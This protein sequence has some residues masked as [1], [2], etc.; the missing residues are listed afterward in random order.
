MPQDKFLIVS[1]GPCFPQFCS[2]ANPDFSS[3]QDISILMRRCR[4]TIIFSIN[5]DMR[6]L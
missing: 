6:D 1:C 4:N 2:E 5:L 3:A